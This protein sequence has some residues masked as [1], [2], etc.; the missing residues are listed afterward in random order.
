MAS[1][2]VIK[3]DRLLVKFIKRGKCLVSRDRTI[4]PQ[5]GQEEQNSIP[6][7]KNEIKIS[8]VHQKKI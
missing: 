4:A 2:V 7:N 6:K 8:P 1:S 3:C 5:P